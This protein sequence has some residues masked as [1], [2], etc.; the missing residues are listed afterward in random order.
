[1]LLDWISFGGL[2][3]V[4][5]WS[6]ESVILPREAVS[7]I[8]EVLVQLYFTTADGVRCAYTSILPGLGITSSIGIQDKDRKSGSLRL[9]THA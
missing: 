5:L 7:E 4:E 2:D 1:M 3:G 8:G 6:H 9:Y